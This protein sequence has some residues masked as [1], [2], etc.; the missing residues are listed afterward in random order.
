MSGC[1]NLLQIIT[2]PRPTYF[3]FLHLPDAKRRFFTQDRGKFLVAEAAAG[4]K[5]VTQMMRPV[6]RFLL[7]D[8]GEQLYGITR[9]LF[10]LED[11]AMQL[12]HGVANVLLAPLLPVM[13]HGQDAMNLLDTAVQHNSHLQNLKDTVGARYGRSL[14]HKQAAVDHIKKLM[15]ECE[16]P[17]MNGSRG[18]GAGR[19]EAPPGVLPLPHPSWRNTG[20]L[21]RN[22]WFEKE[23]VPWLRRRVSE[24]T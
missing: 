19:G 14:G 17:S 10:G 23:L 20:W 24:L 5:G 13:N 7:T 18:G 6:I 22:P 15:V 12:P 16:S 9:G 3:P 8:S 4:L 2:F 21:K 11:E 1:H